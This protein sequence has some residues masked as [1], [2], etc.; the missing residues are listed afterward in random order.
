MGALSETAEHDRGSLLLWTFA[1]R[2]GGA[3][4]GMGAGRVRGL[5]VRP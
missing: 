2:M 5:L 3:T 4:T 1:A